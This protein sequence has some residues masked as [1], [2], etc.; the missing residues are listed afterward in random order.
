MDDRIARCRQRVADEQQ[1]ARDAPDD[2]AAEL[3]VQKAKL[4]QTQLMILEDGWQG[5]ACT[6][7]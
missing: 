7:T 3:H 2:I 1:L 5:V 6:G 4:Y